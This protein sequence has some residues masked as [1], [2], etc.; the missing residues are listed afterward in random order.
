MD[1]VGGVRF[2]EVEMIETELISGHLKLVK[3]YNNVNLPYSNVRPFV[4]REAAK[5]YNMALDNCIAFVY[6]F[7]DEVLNGVDWS[8]CVKFGRFVQSNFDVNDIKNGAYNQLQNEL[9]QKK[10]LKEAKQQQEAKQQ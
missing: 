5:P 6:K 3:E 2:T 9:A 7:I 1:H 10:L 8:E 4:Q